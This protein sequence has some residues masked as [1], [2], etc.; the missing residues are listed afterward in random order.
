MSNAAAHSD[1]YLI[2]GL[3]SNDSKIVAQIYKNHAPKIYNWV[4]QNNGNLEQ[5][6]DLFQ[7]A[8]IDIFRKASHEGFT[9]TCPFDAFLFV[10]CRNK[11]FS[12]LKKDAKMRVTNMGDNEY[13][14]AQAD[15]AEV[16]NYENKYI[17]LIEQ[18]EK[19]GDGCKDL[20]KLSWGGLNMEAVAE[21]LNTTYAY[22]RKKKSLCMAK[23]VTMVKDTAA[24][25]E[26][27]SI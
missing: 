23:L 16:M 19:L 7:D 18:L 6:Q 27:L 11:W 3:V 21:K 24:F 25:K 2:D 9:L 10:V 1:Q 4:Q 8:L 13:I 22:I 5:A 20:L 14:V 15:A 26:L 12:S 17:L